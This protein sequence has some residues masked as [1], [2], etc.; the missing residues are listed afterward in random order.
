M[1]HDSTISDEESPNTIGVFGSECEKRSSLQSSPGVMAALASVVTTHFTTLGFAK[2]LS[3]TSAARS[4]VGVEGEDVG[5][6]RESVL[7]T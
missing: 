1:V 3:F 4:A 2:N 6:P 7:A 5:R